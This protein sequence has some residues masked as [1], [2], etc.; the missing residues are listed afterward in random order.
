MDYSYLLEYCDNEAQ[1]KKVKAM[2]SEG[3]FNKAAIKLGLAKST[4]H[5]S[6]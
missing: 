5:E 6:I 3:S 1:I 2:C 4:V